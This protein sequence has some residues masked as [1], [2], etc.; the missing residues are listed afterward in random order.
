LGSVVLVLSSVKKR[1]KAIR[2]A[3][4]LPALAAVITFLL[5]E[6]MSTQMVVFDNWTLLMVGFALVQAI[7]AM[8]ALLQSKQQEEEDEED[9]LEQYV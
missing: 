6:D 5:T 7:L 1:S 2:L 3:S 9:D 8:L 4:I